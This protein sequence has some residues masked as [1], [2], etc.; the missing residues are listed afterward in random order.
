MRVAVKRFVGPT[1]KE[2]TQGLLSMSMYYQ[3]AFRFCNVRKGNE[4]GHVERSVEYIRRKAFCLV[5]EFDDLA[6]AN[7]H[8]LKI[9]GAL[10]EKEQIQKDAS[11]V[12]QL[13]GVLK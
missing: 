4:K 7:S 5:D 10:N 6:S 9:V 3:F 2:A 13:G 12:E 8:L 1:E 11:A